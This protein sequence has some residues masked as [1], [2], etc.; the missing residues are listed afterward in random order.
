MTE[1]TSILDWRRNLV[2]AA[3]TAL[4]LL[5][6]FYALAARGAQPAQAQGTLRLEIKK[7]L[8]GSN[9][10]RV[11][12]YL[13]FTI[14]ITNTGTISIAL[15][16]LL[17]NYDATI[18]RLER[19]SVPPTTS[20]SGVISWTN[21]T[22]NTLFGPLA[23]NQSISVITV[24]RAIAPKPATVNAA[25]TG[26]LVG[27]N[28]Q[29]GAGGGGQ[30][31]GGTVGGH[32]I[33]HKGLAPGAPPLSG[34]PIT[35]TITISND[36][37]ADIVKLPLLDMYSTQYL[38]FWKASPPPTSINTVTGELRWDDLLPAMG[39]SR[40]RPNEIISVTTVFTALKSVD[41]I[42]LNRAG[43]FNVQ[44]EF[45][46]N[47]DAPRQTEIPIRVLPG[48]GEATAT[49]KPR[50]HKPSEQPTPT[51]S[52]TPG[53][54]TPTAGATAGI[55]STGSVA[56]EVAVT[57]TTGPKNLPRTGGDGEPIA[58][59]LIGLALL[60]GGTLALLYRRHSAG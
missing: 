21:L 45:G 25:S 28:G 8:Q 43:A 50:E 47:V 35:F 7:T 6:L 1:S 4:L 58:W 14:R 5:V 37:A 40:L 18:L 59:L 51:L 12:Q 20:S 48:P 34:Q 15:L 57:P 42:V 53:A 19:T 38:R 56:T 44:D 52:A 23:P 39:L 10:V 32:V 2:T 36:G 13:T 30:A 55:T 9:V 3:G 22:T 46:N 27:V 26:T 17:D 11:G 29:T 16:P 60:L 41:G 54:L 49:P 24:F 33:A 31:G